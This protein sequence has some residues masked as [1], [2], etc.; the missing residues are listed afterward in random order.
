MKFGYAFRSA[1]VAALALAGAAAS[2][3]A[4]AQGGFQMPPEMKKKIAAWQKWQEDHKKL[5][6]LSDQ[7]G[8][9]G[10]M[11]LMP[12][13]E[14][15]KKSATTILQLIS[16]NKAKTSLSEEEAGALAKGLTSALTVKQI[17]K[18]TTIEPMSVKRRKQAQANMGKAPA[19][20]G[21]G[22]FKMPDPPAKGWNPFNP[23]SLPFEAF[24]PIAKK[25]LD[26]FVGDL[27]ARTK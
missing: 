4:K 19:G 27:T 16:A 5:T 14:L 15:D 3:P 13:Y 1:L 21:G 11:N 12:G 22:G 23:D 9:I 24:R 10:E 2:N 26:K 25:N 8:Q 7:I 6:L 18:M 17:K 20:G